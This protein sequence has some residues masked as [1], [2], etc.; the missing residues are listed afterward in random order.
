MSNVN[1]VDSNVNLT[2]TGEDGMLTV[3][4]IKDRLT[5][6]ISLIRSLSE[7]LS[8]LQESNRVKERQIEERL[9]A[10]NAHEEQLRREIAEEE[11]KAQG[12]DEILESLYLFENEADFLVE[13]NDETLSGQIEVVIEANEVFSAIEATES[14]SD[15]SVEYYRNLVTVEEQKR[16]DERGF[17]KL[18]DSDHL[19]EDRFNRILMHIEE[20]SEGV[21]DN[22]ARLTLLIDEH[23][24]RLTVE[25]LNDL[26]RAKFKVE[27][28]QHFN[29][30]ESELGH[31][32]Y[33]REVNNVIAAIDRDMTKQIIGFDG[34]ELVKRLLAIDEYNFT[35]DQVNDLKR[36]VGIR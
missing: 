15:P 35:P 30:Y 32:P 14:S 6:I 34:A 2:M 1:P 13:M 16:W 5:S 25:Q 10:L 24:G 3:N 21:E 33:D 19:S 26:K 4:M 31:S 29:L 27:V 36:S 11:K 12:L 28:C 23:H 9:E 20:Q 17:K 22:I 18:C 7:R 8:T